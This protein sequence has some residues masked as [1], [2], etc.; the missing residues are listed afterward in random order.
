MSVES[1]RRIS[2]LAYEIQSH[3]F[4]IR[5]DVPQKLGGEDT[6]PTP[7]DLLESALA[8]CTAITVQMYANRKQI[9]LESVD[10]KITITAEGASNEM[11]REIRF[12]GN[13][14]DEQKS[15]LLAIAEKCPVHKFI[16]TGA[17]ITSRM[18]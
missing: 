17:K 4:K 13:L 15:S 7:H 2:G 5:T 18:A 1:T 10:V 14:S 3:D 8:G 6:G 16:S 9:P 11:L 12:H